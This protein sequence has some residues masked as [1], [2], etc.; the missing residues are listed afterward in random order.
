MLL[1]HEHVKVVMRPDRNHSLPH[2]HLKFKKQYSASYQIDPF[3]R[4]AGDLPVRYEQR[5]TDWIAKHQ[6]DLLT[7]WK[8]MKEGKHV[9][10]LVIETSSASERS[11]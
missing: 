6:N 3:K 5:V 4:L 11:C 2:F 7:T 9:E 1:Q 8:A 10:G